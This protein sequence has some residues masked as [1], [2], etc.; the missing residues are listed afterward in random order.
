MFRDGGDAPRIKR[1]TGPVDWI[2][3]R[4]R[5]ADGLPRRGG[6]DARSRNR[7]DAPAADGCRDRSPRGEP[8]LDP[9]SHLMYQP[10]GV[11]GAP[12]GGNRAAIAVREAIVEE[13]TDVGLARGVGR[14]A[15]TQGQADG[16]IVNELLARRATEQGS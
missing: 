12:A 11:G 13:A 5:C 16:R 4:V 3:P 8:A 14:G 9:R 2:A 6:A 10:N 15:T 7:D 1:Y